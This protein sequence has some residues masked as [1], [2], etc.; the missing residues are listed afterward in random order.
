MPVCH[1]SRPRRTEAERTDLSISSQRPAK[2][3]GAVSVALTAAPVLS[4]YGRSRYVIFFFF[5]F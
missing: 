1:G 2:F 3:G 4:R 5:F